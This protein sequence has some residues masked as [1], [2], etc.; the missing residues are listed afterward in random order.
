VER[1]SILKVS[2]FISLFTLPRG[3]VHWMILGE[4][5]FFNFNKILT[6]RGKYS[7]PR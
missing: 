6:F 7:S 5:T 3:V 4:E 2:A 1:R